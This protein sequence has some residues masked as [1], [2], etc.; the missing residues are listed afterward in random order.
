MMSKANLITTMGV[1]AMVAAA[2]FAA[3]LLVVTAA[4]TK[5]AHAATTFTVNSTGDENDL[6]FPSGADDNSSDGECDVDSTTGDQCT[7]RAAIQE[8]ND[9]SGPDLINFAIPDDPNTSAD[10]VKTIQIGF[11]PSPTS[12]RSL[13]EIKEAVTIDGYSQPG[14]SPNTNTD[15]ADGTDANLL[16]EL[17]GTLTGIGLRIN[18][19]NVV[20][21]GLV[22]NRFGGGIFIF[23]GGS[24]NT[25]EGNFIGTDPSGGT[26]SPVGNGDYGVNVFGAGANNTIGGTD[27]DDGT[28]DG[29]VEAR[30]LI[31][32]NGK[33]GL[34][35]FGDGG[36]TIQGNLIGTKANGTDS[37]SNAR[38]GVLIFSPNNIVGNSTGNDEAGANLI[39]FNGTDGVQVQG[40]LN[41]T[42]AVGNRILSNS[43][44]SN[45]GPAEG[46][47]GIDLD[48][49]IG[50]SNPDADGV[51][52]NDSGDTDTGPNTLQNFPVLTS[53]SRSGLD[54]STTIE[55]TLNS[56]ASTTFTVQF[57]SGPSADPSNH[58]EGKTYLGQKSDVTTDPS[59]NASFTFTTQEN[60]ALGHFVTATA[61]RLDTSTNPATPTNTS[62]FSEVEEVIEG[63][64][65]PVNS[66]PSAQSADEDSPLVFSG[67][68]GNQISVSDPDAGGS[69]VQ[70]RLQ[71]EHA[72]MT[73]DGD[74]GLTFRPGD[75]GTNDADMTF[76]GTITDINAALDG[77]RFDPE[78]N[79]N[80]SATLTITTDDQGNTGGGGPKTDSDNVNIT[81]NPFNDDPVANNDPNNGS[82]R[83]K[84]GKT[85][86]VSPASGILAN[87]F[88]ADGDTLTVADADPATAGIQPVSGPS[89]GKLTLNANGSFTY[90]APRRVPRNPLTFAYRANDGT[91]D[92]NVATVSIKVRR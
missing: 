88:D 14:A 29:V 47:L 66:V 3:A 38:E 17:K 45:G 36:N 25:I 60:V 81:V 76:T 22:I 70:V 64:D 85:L 32:G 78:A 33:R 1:W 27:A 8:A 90:K 72:T 46:S 89:K 16:I 75:S 34:Q 18:A 5:P 80:G 77:L 68:N 21:K 53:A 26:Q 86:S 51:T 79:Y 50:P 23:G 49:G 82:Y 40:G 59:G 12:D 20:V 10:D 52:T 9:T 61:T 44:F 92:S 42:F 28:V 39:A 67:A 4:A 57:F 24:S 43:I 73:L 37:L 58:G 13:P 35:I 15:L 2:A 74:D 7:L 11:T 48:G 56:T 71:V 30:N 91:S 55:G 69:P 63:N 62:E 65:P 6:D 54:G 31:S 87:D 19:S 83:V 84:A 41:S